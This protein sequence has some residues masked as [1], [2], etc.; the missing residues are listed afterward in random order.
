VGEQAVA[1]T[2]ASVST[3]YPRTVRDAGGRDVVFEQRPE[4]VVLDTYRQMLDE[5]LLLDVAPLGYAAWADEK[6]PF[7][8]Q[9]TLDERSLTA[10][11]FNGRTY[12]AS[13]NFEQ[14]AAA[15]PDLIILSAKDGK[16]EN[17][18]N[19]A[20]FE[21]IAPVFIT[22]WA[23]QGYDRLRLFAAIFSVED[24]VAAIEARDNELFASVTPPQDKA[25]VLGFGYSD[26][27]SAAMQV[28]GFG[29]GDVGVLVRAGFTMKDLGRPKDE[30]SFDISEE[31][32]D[33]VDADMLWSLDPYPGAEGSANSAS[34]L[35][36]QEST[37]LQNLPVWK[38]G[39]FR[40][41][42][43]NQSQAIS[44]WTPLATPFLV[45]TLNELV[46]SYNFK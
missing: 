44:F 11:N 38:E 3:G 46:A 26:A 9:Q 40:L 35:A 34:G 31:R 19:F 27:G 36:F 29:S 2:A 25:L 7:W 24:K 17:V 41:L 18:E 28:M 13:I 23:A 32:F 45:Q 42:N 37:I 15:N 43:F 6:L 22:D 14:L 20:L 10:T 39:R 12:P 16:A 1:P 4:R 5:L 33:I 21:Q 30:F 8:T